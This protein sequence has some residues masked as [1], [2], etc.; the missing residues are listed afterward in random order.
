MYFSRP[1]ELALERS[2]SFVPRA[3]ARKDAIIVENAPRIEVI[4]EVLRPV[5]TAERPVI[6]APITT[7]RPI[8]IFSAHANMT[9]FLLAFLCN[10]TAFSRVG[11][12][13]FC[14]VFAGAC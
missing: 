7:W 12:K 3:R 8:A 11:F 6:S 1:F 13:R 2:G 14:T 4:I 5:V 10:R 9:A